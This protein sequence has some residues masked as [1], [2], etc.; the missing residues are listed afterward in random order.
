MKKNITMTT[1]WLCLVLLT[2]TSCTNISNAKGKSISKVQKIH[3]E[4]E[5]IDTESY[6]N[7]SIAEENPMSIIKKIYVEGEAEGTDAEIRV[8]DIPI[9]YLKAGSDVKSVLIEI[10]LLSGTNTL[11]IIPTGKEGAVITRI[12]AYKVG[13]WVDGRGGETLLVL[14]AKKGKTVTGTVELSANR[15]EWE[16]LTADIVTDNTSHEEALKFAKSY[17]KSLKEG[18]TKVMVEALLPLHMDESKLDTEVTLEVRSKEIR[19]DFT[20]IT[21]DEKWKWDDIKDIVF[22]AKP[23]AN[24]RLYELLRE[25]GSSLFRTN[26]K[27][28][29]GRINFSRMIGRK[30]GKWQIYR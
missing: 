8:N 7:I 3:V 9:I 24:G 23:V 12:V 16:W 5:G 30:D 14:R 13:D 6:T 22:H 26:L 11:S 27:D 4:P 1:F 17:Y 21:I 28:K 15:P 29:Q 2:I 19:D 10:N 20:G 18:D 25:D